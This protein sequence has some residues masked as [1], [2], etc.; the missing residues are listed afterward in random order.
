[1][2]MCHVTH[3]SLN[4]ITLAPFGVK[5]FVT[6]DATCTDAYIANPGQLELTQVCQPLLDQSGISLHPPP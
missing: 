3:C 4:C 1:M 6:R 5:E 2:E